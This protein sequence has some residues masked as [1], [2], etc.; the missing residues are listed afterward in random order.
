MMRQDFFGGI[1][2]SDGL[3]QEF[4]TA[5]SKLRNALV[6]KTGDDRLRD[7]A[8][9]LDYDCQS[10]FLAALWSDDEASIAV[11]FRLPEPISAGEFDRQM[12]IDA[13][14]SSESATF[15]P[16]RLAA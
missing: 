10:A 13:A 14:L 12:F 15:A 1:H 16:A 4:S 2:M 6:Q 8:V 11:R 7:L 5:C 3:G 9:W